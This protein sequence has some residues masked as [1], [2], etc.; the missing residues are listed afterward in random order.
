LAIST[1]D[2]IDGLT[3]RVA[4]SVQSVMSPSA[5]TLVPRSSGGDGGVGSGGN[6]VLLPPMAAQTSLVVE[7]GYL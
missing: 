5:A 4:P 6:L 2:A 3:L 7:L 1:S